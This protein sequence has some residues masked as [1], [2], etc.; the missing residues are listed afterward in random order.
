MKV[1]LKTYGLLRKYIPKEVNPYEIE[2][3]EGITVKDLLNILKIPSEYV[4]IV[5]VGEKKV[6]LTY[7]IKD[8]DELTLLPIMGGG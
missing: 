3:E 4:P 7:T 8:G 1:K 6:D 5:T 2:L